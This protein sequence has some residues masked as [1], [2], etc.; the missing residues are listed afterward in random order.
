MAFE[1]PPGGTKGVEV[2]KVIRPIMKAMMWTGDVMFRLGV[3]VQGRPLLRLT[4]VGARSGR[5]RRAVLAWFPDGDSPD[6]WLVVASNGGSR[7]HPGWAF[8]LARNPADV[9]V[10][11]GDGDMPANVEMLGGTERP[12]AW[13]RIVAMAPGYGRYDE[14]TDREVPIFRLTRRS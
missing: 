6:A 10:D 13:D 4:T 9:M 7:R 3:K 5:E 14:K 11:L 2:P 8:N 1:L 12:S